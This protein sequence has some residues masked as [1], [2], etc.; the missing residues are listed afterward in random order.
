MSARLRAI[1][2][3]TLDILERGTYRTSA[4]ETLL[5]KEIA[6]AVAGTRLYEPD[7][8]LR[9]LPTRGGEMRV[10]VVNEST[11]AAAHRLAGDRRDSGIACL[12]FGSARNPGG[13]L[14]TG[15]RGQEEDVARGSA[16]YPCLRA[17]WDFYAYHR[18]HPELTYSDRV[19]YAP[20]VPVIR[21][22]SDHLL[23]APPL[24]AFLTAAA[25]N[26]TAIA[27][28][29]PALLAGIPNILHRRAT[30][31]LDVAAQHG[32][33]TLVLGAWGCGVFG[34]DPT[35]VATAF[36]TALQRNRSFDR[37]VFAVL[38]GAW[39]QPTYRAFETVLTA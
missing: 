10:E 35:T 4:G 17:A 8:V 28:E 30:R 31:V 38:D 13:G 7:E 14:R 9:G 29:Q 6:A 27:R 2:Q 19:I 1:G 36:A 23:P 37:V 33:T 21:A 24:V 11:L 3:E 25:P 12:V 26:R 15:A 18:G 20:R 5:G 34:N 16:L 32:H 22:G 39:N